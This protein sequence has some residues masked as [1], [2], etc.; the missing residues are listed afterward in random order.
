MTGYK[1]ILTSLITFMA[2]FTISCSSG[3]KITGKGVVVAKHLFADPK[4][5]VFKTFETYHPDQK[6]T[7]CGN[8]VI[9][10][11][12]GIRISED[13]A[14]IETRWVTTESYVFV[15]QKTKAYYRFSSLSDTASILYQFTPEDT[16][17]FGVPWEFEKVRVNVLQDQLQEIDD[18]IINGTAFRRMRGKASYTGNN[19]SI[20]APIIVFFQCDL[21]QPLLQWN[22]EIGDQFGCAFVRMDY[23][24][25]SIRLETIATTLTREQQ[26]LFKA[27][28]RK[29]KKYPGNPPDRRQGLNW[30]TPIPQEQQLK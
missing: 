26:Q 29:T 18:T 10:E 17:R 25:V 28:I 15:N 5:K 8:Y 19:E 21:K 16:T 6:M 12:K 30:P 24:A 27:W 2:A 9:E 23:E 3:N 22:K 11:V 14:G 4:D 1:A 7:F 20:I 13:A